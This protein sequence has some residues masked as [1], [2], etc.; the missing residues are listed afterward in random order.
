MRST[1][2]RKTLFVAMSEVGNGMEDNAKDGKYDKG[3]HND[4]RVGANACGAVYALPLATDAA[5]GSDYVAKSAKTLV[6]GKPNKYADGSPYAGNTCDIDGIA[7]P[8]NIT[9]MEGL[10]HADHRRGHRLGPPERRDLGLNMTSGD[11]TRI[12]S[13]PYGSETTSVY[14]YGNVGGHGYLMAVV[15]HPY[16]ES[17]EDKLAD[18]TDARAYVGYIGPLPPLTN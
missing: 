13:T 18:P 12:F 16:G 6:A 5:I 11:L 4:I 14:S 2:R 10:R 17:D 1:L 9:F 3:G 15:Q 8:D 7:N